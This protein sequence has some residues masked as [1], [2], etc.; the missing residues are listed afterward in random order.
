MAT[1]HFRLFFCFICLKTLR[2]D[3]FY[4]LMMPRR[5][6][7]I[8]FLGRI[9]KLDVVCQSSPRGKLAG[10]RLTK[11]MKEFNKIIEEI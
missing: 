9:N 4:E 5:Y 6:W 10:A 11:S 7:E 3:F 8:R 2:G 1:S